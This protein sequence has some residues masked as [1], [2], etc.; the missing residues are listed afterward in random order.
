MGSI[1]SPR[2]D[3]I[4]SVVFSHMYFFI[5]IKVII[6]WKFLWI[7]LHSINIILWIHDISWMWWHYYKMWV[8]FTSPHSLNQ[9]IHSK[10]SEITWCAWTPF[11]VMRIETRS[12]MYE[13]MYE[14]KIWSI[15]TLG[16]SLHKPIFYGHFL[17]V[18]I[19]TYNAFVIIDFLLVSIQRPPL[20]LTSPSIVKMFS[21][22]I[23]HY[24]Y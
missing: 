3:A 8:Q 10:Y 6:W 20:I 17:I 18:L 23:G 4:L 19:V 14:V 2:G 16:Q 12:T 24:N 5:E 7:K 13:I 22:T 21:M 15:E 11:V 9:W 1:S